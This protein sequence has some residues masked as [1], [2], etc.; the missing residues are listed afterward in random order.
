MRITQ[1]N[2]KQGYLSQGK[3]GE[4]IDKELP[5]YD[6]QNISDKRLLAS[7]HRDYCFLSSAYSLETSHLTISK[8][9]DNS[10]GIA[11]NILPPQ[12]SKPLLLLSEKNDTFPWLDYAFGYGLNNAILKE[13]QNKKDHNS[14]KTVRMFNGHQSEE[15]FINVHVAMVSQT[16]ELLKYQQECLLAL[17]H[18]DRYNFN[19]N[20]QKHFEIF[21]SIINTLQTMWKASN[22]NDYLSFRTFIMGQ[23]GN[24][25]CY[26]T[27]KIF[28]DKGNGIVVPHSYRGETGAQDSI[29]PSVDNF[30][31]LKYPENKLTEY[32]FDLRKY[33][34]KDHQEYIDFMKTNSKNLEFKKFCLEDTNSIIKKFKLFKNV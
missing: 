3:L 7:L 30:L 26:P 19:V 8:S 25:K 23:K 34:P 20:L 31:D 29:I 28:F 9:E 21:Y 12:L 16:G 4:K 11:R 5:L 18:K 1:E 33:R 24:S 2:G 17:S 6:F 14:Y 32:L 10:Y 15:G 22:Y 27:E 13:G